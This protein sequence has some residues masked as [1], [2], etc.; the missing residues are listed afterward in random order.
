V[1]V[2]LTNGSYHAVDSSEQAFKQAA[3]LAMQ[4]GMLNCD[5]ILLE[6]IALVEI[7]APNEFTSQMFQ[8]ITGRRGQVL[9]YEVITGWKGW[10]KITAYLAISEMQDLIVELRSLTMGVGY[11]HWKYDHLQEVPEKLA[12]KIL[13]TYANSE[14]GNGNGNGKG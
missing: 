9:N 13:A 6:P 7:S 12:E 11:F 2:T 14:N 4:T 5:P 1:A 10:D 3:R 8:L